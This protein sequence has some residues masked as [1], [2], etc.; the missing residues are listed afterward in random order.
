MKNRDLNQYP[1]AAELY[2][3][4]RAAHA[5]RAAEVARLVR[6]AFA[7]VAKGLHHA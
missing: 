6:R 2:A 7:F 3:L 4:E 5:A 1:S